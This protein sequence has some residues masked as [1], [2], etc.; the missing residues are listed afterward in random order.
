VARRSQTGS[1]TP[2]AES[3]ETPERHSDG[4][5]AM[6]RGI[7]TLVT[8]ARLEPIRYV[9]RELTR[10]DGSKLQVKV[11]VY[12]PFRLEER[13]IPKATPKATPD[14][15]QRAPARRKAG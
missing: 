3:D 13:P 9:E 11:P 7:G 1:E 8:G 10:P 12:P 5:A 15:R 6:V 4:D 14:S 2:T